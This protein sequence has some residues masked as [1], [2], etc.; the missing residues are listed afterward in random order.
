MTPADKKTARPSPAEAGAR[1]TGD[2]LPPVVPLK[3][4]PWLLALAALLVLGWLV[5][6]ACMAAWE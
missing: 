4:R 1:V 6:L 5:F 2:E 3:K